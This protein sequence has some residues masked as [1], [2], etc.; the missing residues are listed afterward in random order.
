VPPGYDWYKVTDW[1]NDEHVRGTFDLDL[2]AGLPEGTYD[3]GFVLLDEKSG[4]VLPVNLPAAAAVEGE[5][6][7]EPAPRYMRGE[8]FFDAAV[9]VVSRAEATTLADEDRL[10][11]FTFA[12][13]GECELAWSAW[14]QAEH[15]LAKN[16]RWHDDYRP[17]VKTAIAGCYAARAAEAPT[18][19]EQVR[20][21]VEARGY[22]H[23][24]DAVVT[25]ARA[26]AATL[27][28][29]GDAAAVREDWD[30]AY[31]AYRAALQL[32]PRLS[33]TRKKAE[34][35]RD[36]RLGINGKV[37]DPPPK[38]ATKLTAPGPKKA[39]EAAAG[40]GD[41]PIKPPGPARPLVGPRAKVPPQSP[42]P[43]VD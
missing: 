18:Q 22:D 15:H 21:L 4:E 37:K 39:D 40:A 6:V 41:E 42:A 13:I 14:K 5:P 35:A 10:Q 9:V 1:K 19:D 29:E 26:L 23:N 36:K 2:P 27:D 28:A 32:D 31:A 25:P 3:L 38:P 8:I 43:R 33:W 7:A 17:E 24:L 11:A 12:E 34:E 16:T 30:A 20:W